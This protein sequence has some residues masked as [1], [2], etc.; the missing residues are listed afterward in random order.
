MGR[1]RRVWAGRGWARRRGRACTA[2]AAWPSLNPLPS[3]N[4]HLVVRFQP[5]Q[6]AAKLVK[7]GVGVQ[8]DA[9]RQHAARAA[10]ERRK[11]RR[12]LRLAPKQRPPHAGQADQTLQSGG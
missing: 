8:P 3:T 11:E 7:V 9:A 5:P 4:P 2:C 10:D 1:E 6:E 12:A